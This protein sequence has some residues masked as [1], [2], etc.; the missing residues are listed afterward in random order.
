MI[1]FHFNFR[2]PWSDRW[3]IL[4][5]KDYKISQFKALELQTNATT[6]I[7][8]IELRLTTH[9]DHS[10]VFFAVGLLGYEFILNFYDTRHWDRENNR[11]EW[12]A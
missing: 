9:Q 8:G 2:N 10:G 1:S 12:L 11:Y 5:T 7:M 3:R 4:W 6:D